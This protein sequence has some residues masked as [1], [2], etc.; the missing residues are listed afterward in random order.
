MVWRCPD[1]A[2]DSR[3]LDQMTVVAALVHVRHRA[4]L[5]VCVP[6]STEDHVTDCDLLDRSRAGGTVD[7]RAGRQTLVGVTHDADVAVAVGE[8][9]HEF[10]LG[11]VRV[12]VL[13]D[14]DVLEPLAIV[15]EH[16]AVLPEQLDGVGE[17]VVEVH[18][19]G[20][21]QTG[22]VLGIDV[23][24]L[25]VE[26]VLRPAVRLV[27]VDQLVL[28]EADDRVHAAWREPLCVEA[29][30]ADDV[31]GEPVRVGGV[32]D[33]ELAGVAE[34]IGVGSQDAHARRVERRHPHRLHD[35]A[36]ER[37]DPLAHL[38]SGL[39]R[40]RDRQDL[41]RVHTGVDQVRDAMREHAGLARSGAGD[42]QQR[43]GFVG[44][45]VELIGIE[46][47]GERRRTVAAERIDQRIGRRCVG[48]M[49][50]VS[51]NSSSSVMCGPL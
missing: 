6:A 43:A 4:R 27:G 30:I 7:Q 33:R 45:G 31:A 49:R 46:P 3:D 41:R 40:E 51:A 14:E 26:D 25:A 21:E 35:R 39:V 5:G 18:R 1:G 19:P 9:Q 13:V 23:G 17:Q 50:D 36:D 22:L 37:A 12:L 2:T 24:V 10:V 15:L 44:H 48:G 34:R 20:L 38:G 28:P 16:V 29:E 42:H 47:F 32:V 8:Q 11:L